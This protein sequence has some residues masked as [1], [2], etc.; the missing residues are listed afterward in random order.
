ME[1]MVKFFIHRPLMVYLI[2]ILVVAIGFIAMT[3]LRRQVYPDVSLDQMHIQTVCPAAS[4]RDVEVNVTIPLE[5]KIMEVD[6]LEEVRSVS[7]ENYSYI[8]IWIDPDDE[9]KNKVKDDIRRAVDQVTDLPREIQERPRIFEIH[10]SWVPVIVLGLSGPDLS[11]TKLRAAALRM[12]REI[13]AIP[14]VAHVDKLG[15]RD[16]EIR[17]QVNPDKLQAYYLA[18]PDIAAAIKARNIRLT[19]GSLEAFADETTVLTLAEFNQP[20]EVGEVIVRSNFEGQRITVAHL[21]VLEDDFKNDH[22]QYRTNGIPGIG[23]RIHKK[24]SADTIRVMERIKK[25]LRK[26]KP[27]FPP[28]LKIQMVRDN[29]K[30]TTRRLEILGKNALIGFVLV[31]AVLVMFLNIRTAW[32]TA[33]GIPISMAFGIMAHTWTGGSINSVSLTAFIL[34][35]GMLV[36]DAIVVAENIH[37]YQEEGLP[38]VQAALKGVGQVAAPITATISTT[39]VAFLP[40]LSLGG[41]LGLF[42]T[43]IPIIV[44]GTLLGSLIESFF[45]LP[46]HLAASGHKI[47]KWRERG[48]IIDPWFK[49]IKR[50]YC[51]WLEKVLKR[52]YLVVILGFGLLIA[53]AYLAANHIKFVLFPQKGAENFFIHIETTRGSSYPVTMKKV[54]EIEKLVKALP[55]E[56][57]DYYETWVGMDGSHGEDEMHGDNLGLISVG[58]TS[59]RARERE[60]V[61]IIEALRQQAEKITGI[62]SVKFE[63]DTGGPPVG[64]PVELNIIG[65]DF[66]LQKQ[67]AEEML[68]YLRSIPGVRDPGSDLKYTKDEEIIRVDYA[69]LASLNLTVADVAS[70]VRLA[71]E[72]EVVTSVRFKQE[73]VDIRVQLDASGRKRKQLLDDLLVKNRRGKLIPLKKFICLERQPALQGIRHFQGQRV[74]TIT[75][76][77]NNKIITSREVHKKVI[78]HYAKLG[79]GF[80]GIRMIAG[81][82]AE[83]SAKIMAG[84]WK[85][86]ILATLAI[87]FILVLLLNSLSQPL[88]ILCTI[89]FGVIG[90]FLAFWFQ[91]MA[92][93]F[94]AMVGMLGM[95]GVVVN[96]AL[97]IL[98]FINQLGREREES[99]RCSHRT[100]LDASQTR[101]RPVVLTTLTTSAALLPTAYGFGG[102]DPFVVPMVMAMLWGIIF[103]TTLTLFWVPTLYAIGQDIKNRAHLKSRPRQSLTE[104]TWIAPGCIQERHNRKDRPG[105]K[106]IGRK[107]GWKK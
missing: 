92:I 90:V 86:G 77:V 68:G 21:G 20:R 67:A 7:M 25:Y 59:Y 26:N 69:K 13:E 17:V 2:S 46:S 102:A 9:D 87:Y 22:F 107:S 60:A 49:Q 75:A 39:I 3:S 66:E 55:L 10:T 104:D 28:G 91:G 6:G 29:T 56:E 85:A 12:E 19:G 100:I 84:M 89:F 78:Q 11:E 40:L 8:R 79:P 93:G 72:G 36:D 81:G 47:P 15:Y 96:D 97:I 24:V 76:D 74:V 70:T 23:L 98:S 83:E 27:T 16:R 101:L 38:P 41:M 53:T 65:E 106:I 62:K 4:A 94:L 33:L 73:E 88:I 80:P 34:V 30:L 51:C 54:D 42:V 64:R 103:A 61:E 35:M 1:K 31:L 5:E 18:L 71:F 43:M 50:R 52:R 57:V 105:M 44:S 63:L 14:G 48:A 45:I 37:R 95:S 58:L 82:E 99:G 32:W